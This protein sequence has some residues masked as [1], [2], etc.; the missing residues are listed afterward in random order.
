MGL[1]ARV[2][3]EAGVPTLCMTSAWDITAAVKPP[4]SAFVHHPLGHQT[5][6]P[7]DPAGQ[8]KIVQ[9]ALEAAL[10]MKQPGE[11][12]ALPYRWEVEDGWED[13]AYTPEQTATGPDGKPLRG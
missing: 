8:R 4:R 10:S 12:V 2:I 9:T 3:E 6:G 1:I 11:I 5:G 7:D 13:G